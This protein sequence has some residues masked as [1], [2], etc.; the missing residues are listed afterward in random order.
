MKYFLIFFLVITVIHSTVGQL[1]FDNSCSD[2]LSIDFISNS[3]A[4]K[5]FEKHGNK[6]SYINLFLN[7]EGVKYKGRQL[8]KFSELKRV[9]VPP[10]K[11]NDKFKVIIGLER[12]SPIEYLKKLIFVH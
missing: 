11:V 9:I 5:A 2:G 8:S 10:N 6:I 3:E 1:Q 12:S 4:S 7:E